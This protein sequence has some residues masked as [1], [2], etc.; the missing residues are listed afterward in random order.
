MWNDRYR[1]RGFWGSLIAQGVVFDPLTLMATSMA[2]TAAG[3]ALSAVGTLAGGSYAKEAGQ[4]QKKALDQEA[5]TA[6]A[7]GQRQAFDVQDQTRRTISTIAARAGASGVDAGVGSPAT[8]EGSVAQ[9]GSYH[10]LMDM[11][12]GQNKADSL[13][14]QGELAENEGDVKEEASYLSAA[15]TLAS[16]GGSMFKTY[17][18]FTYP[19]QSGRASVSV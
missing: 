3:G 14:Y 8:D 19:T 17:G 7:S 18:A 16:T 2:S 10:A 5:S 4:V 12:N 11:F 15:G 13:R 6:F 1:S 9:R